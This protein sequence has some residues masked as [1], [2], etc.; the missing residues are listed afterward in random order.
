D[1]ASFE[2]SGWC[3][4]DAKGRLRP[5]TCH[6][7]DFLVL[8]T[9]GAAHEAWLAFEEATLSITD[10]ARNYLVLSE[11]EVAARAERGEL[12][13][14]KIPFTSA[15]EGTWF[16]SYIDVIREMDVDREGIAQ[17]FRLCWGKPWG[18]A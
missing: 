14:L 4:C 16:L 7:I 3:G 2:L 10:V 1:N 17:R 6:A 9:C 5:G 15:A 18:T 11:D 13:G 12:G 8:P